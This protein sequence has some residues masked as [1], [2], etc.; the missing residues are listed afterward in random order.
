MP[1][2]GERRL[3]GRLGR[4]KSMAEPKKLRTPPQPPHGGRDRDTSDDRPQK[5]RNDRGKSEQGS[6]AA[7]I[8]VEETFHPDRDGTGF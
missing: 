1:L 3:L 2:F 6:E 5:G 8:E 7:R 4:G